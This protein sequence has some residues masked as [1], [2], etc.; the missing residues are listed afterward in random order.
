MRGYAYDRLGDKAGVHTRLRDYFAAVPAPEMDR[1]D[2][3]EDLAPVIEL[4]HHTV[5]AGR[6][7][8]A[9]ELFHDRLASP[10][11]FRLGAY[12]ACIELLRALFPDREDRPPRVRTERYQSWTANALAN[13]YSL[14]GQPRRAVPLFEMSNALDEKRGDKKNLAIGLGNLADDQLKLSELAVAEINLRRR[15]E[16]CRE[17]EDQFSEAVGHQALGRLLA[18]RGA[19]DEAEYYLM[20][21]QKSFD[22]L[23]TSGSSFVSCVRAYEALRALLMG[24]AEAALESARQARKLADEVARAYF[25]HE[26]DFVQS[27]WLLGAALVALASEGSAETRFLEQAETH[28]TEA[29]T[30]CRR[31]NMVD[32]EPDILLAWARW[33]RARGNPEAARRDAGEALAIAD[34][35]EYRLKQAEIHNFLARLAWERGNALR[36]AGDKAAVRQALA[37]AQ[38][39][40]ETARERARC[41]GP[42]HSYQV[43]LEEAEGT[44]GEMGTAR[45]GVSR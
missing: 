15:I 5:R 32:H 3:V 8:E 2:S 11:Y 38:A 27:E 6:Y 20:T 31:I 28:L 34:R 18:Y 12:Q 43:A 4:Y 23:G 19:F 40:A 39:H 13:S 7:D 41:D 25:P 33:H 16:L 14:S 45:R 26:R 35:C 22:K 9:F 21:G 42:S 36:E 17:I 44:L 37:E 30:R 10:L 1:V 29:L 24:D